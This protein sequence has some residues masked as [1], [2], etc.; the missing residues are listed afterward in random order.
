MVNANDGLRTQEPAGCI[1]KSDA[2]LEVLSA[3]E[4]VVESSAGSIL[5]GQIDVAGGHVVVGLFVFAFNPRS[6]RFIAQTEI[7]GQLFAHAPSVLAVEGKD[8][9]GLLPGFAGANTAAEG[10]GKAKEKVCAAVSSNLAVAST[11]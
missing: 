3:V 2:G 10:L 8:I 5:V 11:T 1:C 7:Q 9:G 6:M 4:A